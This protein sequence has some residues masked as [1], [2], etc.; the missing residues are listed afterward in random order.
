MGNAASSSCGRNKKTQCEKGQSIAKTLWVFVDSQAALKRL[1][2]NSLD[3]GQ[4]LSV[5]ITDLCNTLTNEWEMKITFSWLEG[6]MRSIVRKHYMRIC[7]DLVHFS[8]S[9][10]KSNLQK[11]IQAAYIQLKT[12][13]GFFK[14]YSKVIGKDEE[15][16][17][18]GD[19]QSLQT[20]THLILHCSNY[21]RERKEMRKLL[22]SDLTMTKLFCTKTQI[23]TARWLMHAG[24][25]NRVEG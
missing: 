8:L 4:E 21:S 1:Q 23:S 16:K 6:C 5:L 17:C 19:C 10:P 24:D 15:G 14:S 12:G 9:I 20:P 7:R 11:K 2:K 18:F 22:R 25:V 13:I 3:G